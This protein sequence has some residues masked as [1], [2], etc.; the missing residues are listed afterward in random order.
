MVV[1][2]LNVCVADFTF[3]ISLHILK[4]SFLFNKNHEL[5]NFTISYKNTTNILDVFYT[6]LL[7]AKDICRSYMTGKFLTFSVRSQ[8][9]KM[10]FPRVEH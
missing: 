8:V 4:F 3:S 2:S 5:F 1:V 10:T 7:K 6:T 9:L